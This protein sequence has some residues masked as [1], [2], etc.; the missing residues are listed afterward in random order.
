VGGREDW[1]WRGDGFGL[2]SGFLGVR[3]QDRNGTFTVETT[4]WE[5]SGG[6]R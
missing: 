5:G 3:C 1:E 6:V 4:A 2:T